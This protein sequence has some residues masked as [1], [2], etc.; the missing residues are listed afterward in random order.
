MWC[1]HG[2][3]TT[4]SDDTT[5]GPMGAPTAEV[6][7]RSIVQ[8]W[9]AFL[10][11]V[12]AVAVIVPVIADDPASTVP[13]VLPAALALAA[14]AAALVGAVAI[15]RGLLAARPA[16]DRAAV[17]ELRTR[18]VL[19]MAIAEFPALLGVA[20]AFVLGPPWVATV[21][22]LPAVLALLLVR[23]RAARFDRIDAAWRAG[24]ADASLRRALLA[25]RSPG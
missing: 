18:L 12:A 20:L 8:L 22:A 21:G 24:G 3:E 10:V 15:D 9:W 25:D 4:V 17:A 19:Q 7:L 23:P 16:D 1:R 6:G 5:T 14:G 13:A 2:P 11:V